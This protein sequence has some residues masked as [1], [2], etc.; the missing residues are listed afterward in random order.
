MEVMKMIESN[1]Y[2]ATVI[3]FILVIVVFLSLAYILKW[4][5]Y[6]FKSVFHLDDSKFLNLA[7]YIPDEEVTTLRQVFYLVMITIFVSNIIYILFS[8]RGE[9]M[10]LLLV[11]IAISLFLVIND[12]VDFSRKLLLFSLIPFG[13]ISCLLFGNPYLAYL[14]LIHILPFIYFIKVYYDK[15]VEYTETNSLGIT[16][17]LLFLIVFISFFITMVFEYKRPLD[18]LVM[19][20]NAFTSNGYSVLGGT[21]PGK[22]NAIILVWSGFILSG[23]GT[24]T[25][26]VSIVMKHVDKKFDRLEKLIK[27]NKK[28]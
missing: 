11:D 10:N 24:A 7:E 17:M 18:S 4:G 22:V 3:D 12:N 21:G 23:V 25:L 13:S 1:I 8:W 14:D 26:A 16:I 20:S 19:V 27:K 6:K 28:N 9:S 5:Y 15:F 2:L